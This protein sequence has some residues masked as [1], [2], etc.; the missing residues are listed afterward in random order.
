MISKGL[1]QMQAPELLSIDNLSKAYNKTEDQAL[2]DVSLTVTEGEFVCVI[3]PS[4][5]GKSTLLRC[6]NRLVD[7]TQGDLVF[8]GQNIT[9]VTGRALREVR[10]NIGMVF[11]NYNLVE[12]RSVL[13]NVLHGKLGHKSTLAGALGFY[14]EA[15]KAEAFEI[16]EMFGLA[17]LAYKRCS[18]LSGGQKQRVGIARAAMQHPKLIL[19]DEPIASLDPNSAEM[20]MDYLR[21]MNETMGI[22]CI[23]NLHHVDYAIQYADRIVGINAGRVVHDGPSKAIQQHDL[24]RI[25]E[26]RHDATVI[27]MRST[28]QTQPLS[29]FLGVAVNG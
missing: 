2:T 26:N 9:R 7:A 29:L 1:K 18:E 25:Y 24:A 8:N 13:E 21:R 17:K 15:E 12:R 11:Q 4:G 3:G 27:E 20:I 16:L 28:A 19:C 14:T 5:A 10:T 6:I 22:T 23:V